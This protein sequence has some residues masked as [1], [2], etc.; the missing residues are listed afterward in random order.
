MPSD[1]GRRRPPRLVGP[2]RRA[3]HLHRQRLALL[4]EVPSGKARACPRSAACAAA[5][6]LAARAV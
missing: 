6:S 1:E 3:E 5:G 4:R 2:T